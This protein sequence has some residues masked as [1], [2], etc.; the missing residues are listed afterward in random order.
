MNKICLFIIG[1]FLVIITITSL[2]LLSFSHKK[3]LTDDNYYQDIE[4]NLDNQFIQ[5]INIQNSLCSEPSK[6]ILDLSFEGV[7]AFCY[8]KSSGFTNLGACS[9]GNRN[10]GCSSHSGMGS[11]DIKNLKGLYFCGEMSNYTYDDIENVQGNSKLCKS[12]FKVCG[13]DTLKYLCFPE[14]NECPINDIIIS[15]SKRLDL[16]DLKYNEVSKISPSTKEEIFLYTTNTKTENDIPVDFQL[17]YKNICINPKEE[18]SPYDQFKYLNKNYHT[19]CLTK[20][21]LKQNDDRYKK[22]YSLDKTQLYHDNNILQHLESYSIF[23]IDSLRYKIDLFS[24]PFIH[25]SSECFKKLNYDTK[26]DMIDKL[27]IGDNTRVFDYFTGCFVLLGFALAFSICL[28]CNNCCSTGNG[29]DN[30][31]LIPLGIINFLVFIVLILCSISFDISKKRVEVVDTLN[32]SDCG[33]P[34]LNGIF[35]EGVGS[36]KY[37]NNSLIAV[38]ILMVFSLFIYFILLF[39]FFCKDC[40]PCDCFKFKKKPKKT[41]LYEDNNKPVLQ[42]ISIQ[43]K[44]NFGKTKEPLKYEDQRLNYNDVV[45]KNR[46]DYY[47][48]HNQKQDNQIPIFN[49]NNNINQNNNYEPQVYRIPSIKKKEEDY[50]YKDS[51]VFNN[52]KIEDIKSKKK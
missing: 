34:F 28:N 29:A 22:I 47:N 44:E 32:S 19:R 52:D 49:Y 15:D 40:F 10:K 35:K 45:Y 48:N 14:N 30:I 17:G 9:K 33:D 20:I 16:L 39:E 11:R 8:C 12:G 21:I 4:R 37:L 2:I 43:D 51:N 18:I 36:S 6:N 38:I 23:K 1:M 7:N 26:K 5:K 46:N 27:T 31:F 13:K 50:N 24:R 25:L 3:I 41:L 42:T